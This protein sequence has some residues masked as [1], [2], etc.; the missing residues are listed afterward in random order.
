MPMRSR[1]SRARPGGRPISACCRTRCWSASAQAQGGAFWQRVLERVGGGDAVLVAELDGEIV[2]FVS[3]GPIRERI[4][5]YSGEFYAL[6]VLPE[7]QG[8]GIG[9]ALIAHAGRAWCG[10]AGSAPRSGC[11][12]TTISAAAS[13]R[14]LGGLPLGVAKTLAYRGTS[15]PDGARDRLWLAGPAPR[16]L[17]GRRARPPLSAARSRVAARGRSLGCSRRRWPGRLLRRPRAATGAARG[18]SAAGADGGGSGRRPRRAGAPPRRAR[19]LPR[20]WPRCSRPSAEGFARCARARSRPTAGSGSQTLPGTER[21]TIEGE[22]WPRARYACASRAVPVRR[23]RRRRRR[24]F[25]ALGGRASTP[26]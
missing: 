17:A 7:A 20:C 21:C 18:R 13:T 6:Y 14:R 5:G 26:A 9:T 2:G 8:C 16:A 4:P 22:A 1:R 10:S 11:S 15:Y 3:S 12:R 23:P 24:A 19:A 25:D